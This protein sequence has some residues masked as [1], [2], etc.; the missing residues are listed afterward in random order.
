MPRRPLL[1]RKHA[2]DLPGYRV[3][4][5][6]IR[7]VL[8]WSKRLSDRLPFEPS[9]GSKKQE[10]DAERVNEIAG[11]KRIA[12]K[13]AERQQQQD[14]SHYQSG[15]DCKPPALRFCSARA[16]RAETGMVG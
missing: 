7:L 2:A 8:S 9:H 13:C 12:P 10:Y 5:W 1:L 3:Y 6:N 14:C 11:P 4:C 16:A 15:D